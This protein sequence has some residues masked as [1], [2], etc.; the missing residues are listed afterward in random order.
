MT[1]RGRERSLC[2]VWEERGPPI[3]LRRSLPQPAPACRV[4]EDTDRQNGFSQVCREKSVC[5]TCPRCLP[6]RL[7][8]SRQAC[9]HTG[10]DTG[11]RQASSFP[12]PGQDSIGVRSTCVDS[13]C[14]R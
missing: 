1:H 2:G 10:Q 3:G 4:C 5:L 8:R 14:P 13:D 7:G 11:L 9:S 12:S 6:V